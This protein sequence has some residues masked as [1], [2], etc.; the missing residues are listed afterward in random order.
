MN[1]KKN[2]IYF[3]LLQVAVIVGWYFNYLRPFS[4][5]L[6]LLLFI[7]IEIYG[8]ASIS[9]GFHFKSICFADTQEKIVALTFDDGPNKET[10]DKI[11]S[12]LS[13]FNASATFFCIGKNI[14]GNEAL[15]QKI[16]SQGHL[17][18]NHSFTHSNSFDIKGTRTIVEEINLCN[19][20]ISKITGKKPLLFR[21]PYGVSTPPLG[22]AIKLTGMASIGWS[23]RSLDTAKRPGQVIEGIKKQLHP[24]AIIL[25]HDTI[26]GN[27]N[28]V[29]D[30]LA[31][32]TENS[33]KVV[34]LN[35]LLNIQVYA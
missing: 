11:L 35:S 31:Y 2:I 29:R 34:P 18:G 32:L 4:L 16:H 7:A 24:G 13:E 30:L 20:T 27:E 17:I 1:H 33:Y 15:L 12:V 19:E 9:S 22:R 25:L 5:P 14:P 3:V 8:A 26:T 10:T 21:P 28:L 6:P 23:I